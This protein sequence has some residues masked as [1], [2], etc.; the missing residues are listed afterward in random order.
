ML[1]VVLKRSLDFALKQIKQTKSLAD[2]YEIRLDTFAELN[3]KDIE[4]LVKTIHRPFIL[5]LRKENQGG[6]Y[7]NDIKKQ[8]EKLDE[9]LV[10]NPTYIDLEFDVPSSEIER[11]KKKYPDIKI[12]SSFHEFRQSSK[13]LEKLFHHVFKYK[14][15][16]Y[17]LVT[18]ALSPL[19]TLAMLEFSSK[20]N[21][22]GINFTGVCLGQKGALSR[23]LG[24]VFGNV[25]NYASSDDEGKVA[26]GQLPAETLCRVYNFKDLNKNTEIF[27][28]I[29]NPVSQSVSHLSH[30][31]VFKSLGLNAVY[32]KIELEKD[33]LKPF[34]EVSL[35]L[36]LKG[37][38]IT[39]PFKED[40]Y[41]LVYHHDKT[42]EKIKAVNTLKKID[43]H[44][45]S[46]N[47][48]AKG[49]LDA[50]EEL[51][52][53]QDK[54]C[55]VLGGGGTARAVAFEALRRKAKVKILNRTFEKALNIAKQLGCEAF[56]FRKLDEV[57]NEKYHVLVNTTTVGMDFP[58]QSPL[59]S[60]YIH[61]DAL[62]MDAIFKTKKTRLL[63]DAEEKGCKIVYGYTMFA[64]Q[65]IGQFEYWFDRSFDKKTLLDIIE[66]SY[67]D[68][69]RLN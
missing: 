48:D 55:I 16:I 38:S 42:A 60:Q 13:D 39:V 45:H 63:K 47:T 5:T 30:N 57:F 67:N 34:L 31:R 2:C 19:D 58:N 41:S 23:I 64:Y 68:F 21:K 46:T 53:V 26:E 37:L 7:S 50:I 9:F 20:M 25:I 49:A 18:T 56:D 4:T 69:L 36:P 10:L 24:P 62:I 12:I 28:L 1:T 33:E 44:W 51:C 65:A 15:D 66:Q 6:W 11:I 8:M 29:G 14:A 27:A 3:F 61:S 22:K 59:N 35:G 43:L 32:V 52:P 54:T 40:A 17:K